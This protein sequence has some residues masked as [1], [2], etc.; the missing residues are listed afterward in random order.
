MDNTNG[1][2]I[3]IY[4]NEN[5]ISFLPYFV[6][7]DFKIEIYC[8]VYSDVNNSPTKSKTV[9]MALEVQVRVDNIHV[10]TNRKVLTVVVLNAKRNV[11]AITNL[12]QKNSIILSLTVKDVVSNAKTTNLV[13]TVKNKVKNIISRNTLYNFSY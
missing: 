13:N 5:S 4:H 10:I 7:V 2:V 9:N 12:I 1:N 3:N 11:T 6:L 8:N